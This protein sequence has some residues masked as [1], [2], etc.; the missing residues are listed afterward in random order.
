MPW[1][2]V[3]HFFAPPARSFS[4]SRQKT[5]FLGLFQNKNFR[6]LW[7]NQILG[8]FSYNMINFALIIWVERLTQSAIATG[9]LAATIFA[10]PLLFGI[11][12]GVVV[13][14]FD[15]R[16]LMFLTKIF[17][18]LTVLGLVVIK[19][20][21][22]W[23]LLVAFIVNCIDQFYVPSESSSLPML[24]CKKE[25]VTAN[26]LFSSTIYIGMIT[27]FVLGGPL[28]TH[29]GIDVPFAIASSL[30]FIAAACVFFLP[31]LAPARKKEITLTKILKG[32]PI[33]AFLFVLSQTKNETREGL[34]FI[35][36]RK[37][38]YLAILLLACVQFL[39]GVLVTLGPGFFE[40]VLRISAADL[41]Y[42]M[43]APAGAGLFLGAMCL[44]K[45]GLRFSRRILISRAMTAAGAL[46]VIFSFSQKVAEILDHPLPVIQKPLP[47]TQFMGLST[48]LA[49]TSFLFGL[50]IVVIMVLSMSS[51]QEATP[52][53]IRGRVFGVLNMI[54]FGAVILPVL[55]SGALAESIGFVPVLAGVGT[56]IFIV[57]L[58]AQRPRLF[59]FKVL[60]AEQT[61]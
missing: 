40:R 60:P 6:L 10:P 12:A 36:A 48:V 49:I 15:R 4:M 34:K 30:T 54:A 1:A 9:L 42:F 51:L 53:E 45:W 3:E 33:D 2:A 59:E 44:G 27:G 25:L 39:L 28:I 43:M 19:E 11:F 17:W 38:V 50:A 35:A 5:G 26:S 14:S 20:Q 16:R 29:F 58:I 7:A 46:F 21:L 55:I 32:T 52:H 24:V 13:D 31:S 8:Q 47:F 18:A 56:L 57:G 61:K 22:F 37:R 41:S 23:V